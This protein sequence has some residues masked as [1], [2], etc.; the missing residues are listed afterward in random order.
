MDEPPRD[1]YREV[2]QM[3]PV[4]DAKGSGRPSHPVAGILSGLVVFFP[5]AVLAWF[6]AGFTV[7]WALIVTL[8]GLLAAGGVGFFIGTGSDS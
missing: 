3:T 6:I 8:F 5:F 1:P 7:E 4:G 2:W